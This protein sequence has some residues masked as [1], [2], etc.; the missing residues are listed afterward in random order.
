MEL[1][2]KEKEKEKKEKLEK[3][4]AY[5]EKEIEETINNP[6][7]KN[8]F[9]WRF[10]FPEVL[11][12]AGNFIGFNVIIGNPPYISNWD[13][14][15]SN[16]E[17]VDFLE[18][19]YTPYLTG[20][21]DL[22][23]CFIVLANKLMVN[24]GY[25]S[26][27]LP[28]SFYK[29]KHSVELRK[30]FV[31]EVKILELID[32]GEKVVFEDVARQTGI[33]LI[34]K[35]SSPNNEL[36]LKKGIEDEGK[37]I[38]QNFFKQLKNFAF[39]TN[40]ESL[41]I[42]IFHKLNN[43]SI[44]LG[45]IVCINTGVVAHSKKGSS[46]SFTKD[47]VI[48]KTNHLGYKKY[49]IGSNISPYCIIFNDDY[50][51]YESK[52]YFFHRPKYP[53]LFESEKIIVRRISGKNNRFVAC[54]DKEQYYSNDNLM[55]LVLWNDEILE[56][57]KPENKWEIIKSPDISLKYILAIINSKLVTYFFSKFLS[58]DTLQGSYSSIYP[59]DI[60]QIPIAYS[61]ETAQQPIIALVEQVLTMKQAAPSVSTTALETE[62]DALVYKLYD[63]TEAE[64]AIIE[65][66]V[67]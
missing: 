64:I 39:K 48:S 45:R 25:N 54:Y 50:M 13:L 53:L 2:S 63:L 66:S 33:F 49:A 9:E 32:F 7:Y 42:S 35:S 21:W 60:R 26:Y 65:A 38:P 29:E 20:H 56:F 36:K 61:F 55:H 16:R 6:I 34:Q 28:T 57:Q 41:D 67:K 27:I 10:E 14:S 30:F 8:A 15:E 47:D 1:I 37:V 51:D 12:N 46:I 44:L 11:D 18:K 58:T 23:G 31:N 52:K 3:E 43:N 17:V 22:F 4:I 19:E 5:L 40:V 24:K 59:D 62:I